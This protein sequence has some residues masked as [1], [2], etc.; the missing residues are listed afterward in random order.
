[1]ITQTEGE[2]APYHGMTVKEAWW[3]GYRAGKNLPADI[4]R[5]EAVAARV[6]TKEMVTAAAKDFNNVAS[7]YTFEMKLAEA[8]ERALATRG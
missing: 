5:Q 3:A 4:P 2:F 7:W 8:I 6:V 1:M